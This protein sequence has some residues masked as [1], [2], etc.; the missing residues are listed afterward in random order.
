MLYGWD[1]AGRFP[2]MKGNVALRMKDVVLLA[3]SV[4]LLKP[5]AARATH[6]R[7]VPTAHTET[8]R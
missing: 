8:D 4:Y 5:D 3:T 7:S 2:A 1:S 6:A